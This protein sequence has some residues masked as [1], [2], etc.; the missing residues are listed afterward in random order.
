MT[1]AAASKSEIPEDREQDAV[2]A[3]HRAGIG[4]AGHRADPILVLAARG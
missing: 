4:R 3:C 2:V 1:I